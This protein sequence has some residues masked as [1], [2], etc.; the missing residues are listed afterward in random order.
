MENKVLFAQV[1]SFQKAIFDNTFTLMTASQDQSGLFMNKTLEKT[2]W[3]PEN[4]KKACLHWTEA[5]QENSVQFKEL[6][7][8]CFDRVE[9][10]L[11]VSQPSKTPATTSKSVKKTT[12]AGK[13]TPSKKGGAVKKSTAA[14]KTAIAGKTT[15]AKKTTT[16]KKEAPVTKSAPVESTAAAEDKASPAE[17]LHVKNSFPTKA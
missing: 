4:S 8:T 6:V 5:L 11:S 3:F 1:F 17:T 16:A 14:A 13:R 2:P 7:N 15:A 10:W 12:V 9:T